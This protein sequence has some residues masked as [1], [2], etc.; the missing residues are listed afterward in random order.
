MH[1]FESRQK[2]V[3]LSVGKN[4]G[5]TECVKSLKLKKSPPDAT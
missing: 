5:A 3:T 1:F 2:S 4:R